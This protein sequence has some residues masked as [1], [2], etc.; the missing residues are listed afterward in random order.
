L[1]K[2]KGIEILIIC[3]LRKS[4][5]ISHLNLEGA[6]KVI[7]LISPEKSYL[8]HMSHE[9][10]KHADLLKELPAN[11]FPAFDGLVLDIPEPILIVS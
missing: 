8:T 1:E 4:W 7:E 3:A 2:L 6:L 10:G 11:V 9:I 5:H